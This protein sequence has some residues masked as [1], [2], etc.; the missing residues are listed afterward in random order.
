MVSAKHLSC[1][2]VKFMDD[3]AEVGC[4]HQPRVQLQVGGGT[5]G[6]LVQKQQP[7]YQCKKDQGTSEG[8]RWFW[9]SGTCAYTSLTTSPG[10][11]TFL[12]WLGRHLSAYTSSGGWSTLYWGTQSWSPCNILSWKIVRFSSSHPPIAHYWCMSFIKSRKHQSFHAGNII[13][14]YWI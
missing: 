4:G 3:T 8:L 5:P 14:F 1:L 7:L 13:F 9:P 11:P 12:A 6:G 2:I 10:T